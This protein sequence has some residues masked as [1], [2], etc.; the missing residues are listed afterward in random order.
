MTTTYES[1]G[2][3]STRRRGSA[4]LRLRRGT[5]RTPRLSKRANGRVFDKHQSTRFSEIANA[6]D[7]NEI[8]R[9]MI[10]RTSSR[11]AR[12]L[13]VPSTAVARI[14]THL[15]PGSLSMVS[16]WLGC[17]Y[18]NLKQS[19]SSRNVRKLDSGKVNGP[20]LTSL[21]GTPGR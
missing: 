8:V 10:S 12:N 13:L 9:R 7:V 15:I 14:L 19:A 18:P 20:S 5:R 1:R 2:C 4:Y 3:S 6:C 17:L 11:S 16:E 21:F